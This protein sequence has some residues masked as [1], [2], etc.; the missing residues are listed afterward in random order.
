MGKKIERQYKAQDKMY[1]VQRK[2]AD[3]S[4]I[5]ANI[6]EWNRLMKIAD[7]HRAVAAKLGTERDMREG[8]FSLTRRQKEKYGK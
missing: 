2:I 3:L 5:T 8:S 4:P 7:K 1:K 6:A